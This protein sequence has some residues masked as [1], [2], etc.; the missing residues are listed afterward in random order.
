LARRK[1]MQMQPDWAW[2]ASSQSNETS[3]MRRAPHRQSMGR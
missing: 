3:P 1:Y 2:M